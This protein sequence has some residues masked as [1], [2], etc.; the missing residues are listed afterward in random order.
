VLYWIYI[1]NNFSTWGVTLARNSTL[2]QCTQ[3]LVKIGLFAAKLW[4]FKLF[5]MAAATMLDF[6]IL[7]V[8]ASCPIGVLF[9]ACISNLVTIRC[10]TTNFGIFTKFK[11]AAVCHIGFTCF[12]YNFFHMG[13]ISAK[14]YTDVQNLKKI[15]R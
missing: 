10:S 15:R 6:K 12:F 14:F 1:L 11:M 3:N 5:N 2:T 9:W 8:F 7:A 4:Y 13:H